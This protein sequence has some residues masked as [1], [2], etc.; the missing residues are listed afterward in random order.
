M[1]VAE[2]EKEKF[3][4]NWIRRTKGYETQEGRKEVF[5]LTMH[6]IHLFTVINRQTYGKG[7]L[8]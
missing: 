2:K 4:D 8:R 7:P 3:N 5:Y 1:G 6:S